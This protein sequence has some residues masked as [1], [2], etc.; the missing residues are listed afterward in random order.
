MKLCGVVILYMYFDGVRVYG[1][2]YVQS[3]M[4]MCVFG[5]C[6]VGYM[7]TGLRWW[8]YMVVYEPSIVYAVVC[9]CQRLC[10]GI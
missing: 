8:V 3:C 9:L 4:L 1:S 5:L 6:R 7:Y 10:I 2:V